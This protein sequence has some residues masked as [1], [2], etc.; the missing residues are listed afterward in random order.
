MAVLSRLSWPW[1]SG[2]NERQIHQENSQ[3]RTPYGQ[4]EDG[5]WLPPDLEQLQHRQY[6]GSNT[7]N[8]ARTET[9]TVTPYRYTLHYN[10]VFKTR[11]TI[12]K[13][14]THRDDSEVY[15]IH[16]L[17]KGMFT[18]TQCQHHQRAV[19]VTATQVKTKQIQYLLRPRT[20]SG[21]TLKHLWQTGLPSRAFFSP[22]DSTT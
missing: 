2:W 15:T 8:T 13:T 16:L 5:H 19:S 18:W 21:D 12:I 9:P 20:S 14:P 6:T 7:A 22:P 17:S 1:P 10:T 11:K 4:N 3:N